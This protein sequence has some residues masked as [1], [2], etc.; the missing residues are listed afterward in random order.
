MECYLL[1]LCMLFYLCV[2]NHH[3]G[4]MI[5]FIN[6]DS[7]LFT[8]SYMVYRYLQIWKVIFWYCVPSKASLDYTRALINKR[9]KN[10]IVYLI[11]M[12]S[13]ELS[14]NLTNV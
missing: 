9:G 8:I 6:V 12:Y 1:I 14:N 4:H 13:T 2:G 5:Y 11:C 10:I 3:A 7:K